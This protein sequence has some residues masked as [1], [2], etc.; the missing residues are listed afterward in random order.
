M[1]RLVSIN[2]SILFCIFLLGCA[3]QKEILGKNEHYPSISITLFHNDSFQPGLEEILTNLTMEEFLADGRLKVENDAEAELDISG[4]I[5]KYTRTAL[6]LDANDNV[7]L[8]Q[9]VV[10]VDVNVLDTHTLETVAH[11]PNINVNT[12]YVPQRSDIE[13]ETE[14]DAQQRLMEDL[15]EEIVYQLIDKDRKILANR[16]DK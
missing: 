11:Y 9:L 13:F 16:K 14:I 5:K 2:I 7:T 3:N 8:Y 4:R 6:A 1:T 12:T 10:S 15:A